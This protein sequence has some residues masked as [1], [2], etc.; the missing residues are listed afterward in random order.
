M[1]TKHF[2]YNNTIKDLYKGPT[3]CLSQWRLEDKKK[4]SYVLADL[5]PEYG[6]VSGLV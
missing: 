6:N 3:S 5:Y 1:T 4:N 2:C